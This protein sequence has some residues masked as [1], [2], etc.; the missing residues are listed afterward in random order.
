[1]VEVPLTPG[2]ELWAEVVIIRSQP[3]CLMHTM[4]FV[5]IP[6]EAHPSPFVVIEYAPASSGHGLPLLLEA[7]LLVMKPDEPDA[8]LLDARPDE[9]DAWLLD[10]R[11]DEPDAALLEAKPEELA[12][13]A[14][15]PVTSYA[16]SAQR[17]AKAAGRRS[18]SARRPMRKEGTRPA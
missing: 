8:W 7:A 17:A 12:P 3:D 2:P 11:P 5:L 10:A 13:P 16:G 9:P 6:S 4:A 18:S 1:M 15:E 14:L